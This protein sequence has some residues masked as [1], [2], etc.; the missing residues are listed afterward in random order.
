[1]Y[2]PYVWDTSD[3]TTSARPANTYDLLE[4]LH[5]S[6]GN[7]NYGYVNGTVVGP[8]SVTTTTTNGK[9]QIG[10]RS[11]DNTQ[12]TGDFA[13]VLI[14][15]SYLNDAQRQQV[16]AYLRAKWLP[17]SLP[18]NS[19]LTIAAGAT[20]DVSNITHYTLGT[21]A[22]LSARGTGTT[23]GA[24]AA[25]ITG[26]AG[27]TV[28]LGARPVTLNY[29][30]THPALVVSQ[31]TL[32]LN[33]NNFTVVV[34]GAALNNGVYTLV[35]T[36]SPI[37][38]TVNPTPSFTGGNGLAEARTGV[39]S[40]SGNNVILTVTGGTSGYASWADSHG[41]PG[42]PAEGDFDHDGISNLME[43]ALGLD[44]TVSNGPVGT[45]TG[46]LLSFTKGTAAVTNNDVT[47]AIEESD[48]LDQWTVVTNYTEN[49]STTIS[50][51]L[52]AGKPKTF[53]RLMVTE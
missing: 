10:Y 51:T 4:A 29:D 23:L 33:G 37:T 1:M 19:A 5:T 34:P 2:L 47:Y 50:Y 49:N 53:A 31:G 41:I 20:L 18:P 22:S 44:P 12:V 42:Q 36:P 15:N 14:Y 52:P 7:A 45:L 21:G 35:T 26:V 17:G 30:S 25:A 6:A 38:G 32:S 27:G 39:V 46:R 40:I 9:V 28:S 11:G 13:E 8:K 43:Y 3:Q 48:D 24:D 16:E